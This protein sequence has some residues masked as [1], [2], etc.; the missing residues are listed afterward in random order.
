M[1]WCGVV[2]CGLVWCGVVLSA[3]TVLFPLPLTSAETQETRLPTQQGPEEPTLL[4]RKNVHRH[5][6]I[7]HVAP[8]QLETTRSGH[9]R[10]EESVPLAVGDH[11]RWTFPRARAVQ[12]HLPAWLTTQTRS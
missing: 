12:N 8:S 2:W 1:V 3:E 7:L 11:S 4:V 5:E 9:V 10:M 6:E